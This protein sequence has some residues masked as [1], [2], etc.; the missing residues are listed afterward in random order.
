MYD[1]AGVKFQVADPYQV[2]KLEAISPL[3][4][5]INKKKEGDEQKS[6][7]EQMM[8]NEAKSAYKKMANIH[9]EEEVL[10]A[11]Q[12][13]HSKFVTIKDNQKIIECWNI[14]LEN[15]VKQIPVVGLDGKIKALATMKSIT[16]AMMKNR[17]NPTYVEETSIYEISIK[18]VMTAEPIAD[19]RRVAKVM[20]QY[21]LNTIP[22]VDGQK[23]EVV[24]IISRA[25]ILR[26]ISNNPH[27]QLWA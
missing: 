16:T 11:Y 17:T 24:G 23:D 12:L 20:I 1:D 10:H 5:K 19:I 18:D 6:S 4:N 26:A 8:N 2:K 15:D 9:I 3:Q 13:M 22:I 27:Y 14:M 7:F 25:D 21:H